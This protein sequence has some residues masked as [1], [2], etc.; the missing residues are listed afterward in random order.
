MSRLSPSIAT[1]SWEALQIQPSL[2]SRKVSIME[3][4]LLSIVLFIAYFCTLSC[5]LYS[6]GNSEKSQKVATKAHT[7]P[8]EK[9]VAQMLDELENS[10]PLTVTA[11]SFP[12]SEVSK[13]EGKQIESEFREVIASEKVESAI[14]P[15]IQTQKT[16]LKLKN[17][18]KLTSA[19]SLCVKHGKL[20]RHSTS[21]RKSTAK[22]PQS[23]GFAFRSSRKWRKN[24]RRSPKS[25][26]C[27]ASRWTQQ[28]L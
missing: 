12:F 22:M 17:R 28:R 23:S 2:Q 18:L 1:K 11:E 13:D 4:T 10:E 5:L 7:L 9:A 21:T 26:K 8:I 15:P 16:H 27:L 14:E 20:P 6:P 3:N 24:Q 25:M 19:N